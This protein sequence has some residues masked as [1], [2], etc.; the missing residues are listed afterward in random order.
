MVLSFH[1]ELNA[2]VKNVKGTLFIV[3]DQIEV[4]WAQ[5]PSQFYVTH[6]SESL[7]LVGYI[8]LLWP[9]GLG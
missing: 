2:G 4:T 3:A 5:I 7:I 6:L 1:L 9:I 8:H